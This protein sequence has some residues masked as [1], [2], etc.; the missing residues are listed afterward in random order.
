[1][2]I[3]GYARGWNAKRIPGNVVHRTCVD[4]AAR[5]RRRAR[6]PA[7]PPELGDEHRAPRLPKHLGCPGD[8]PR[9]EVGVPVKYQ[10]ESA[11][12]DLTHEVSE[13]RLSVSGEEI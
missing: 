7:V 12:G 4:A 3:Q 8:L 9:G 1:M 2:A 10:H 13:Q 11:V 5:I 6:Q